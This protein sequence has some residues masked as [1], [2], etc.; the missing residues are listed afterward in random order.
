MI[1]VKGYYYD[2]SASVQT[3][4]DIAFYESGRVLI[5]GGSLKLETSLECLSIASRIG[6]SRRSIYLPDGGKLE[7]DD[8][9]AIDRVCRFFNKNGPQ[10]WLHKLEKNWAYVLSALL[11]TG[12]FVW[13][14]IEFGV[15]IVAK[16]VAKNLPATIER[17]IGEQALTQL[18]GWVFTETEID[19]GTQAELSQRLQQMM[20][21]YETHY[22]YR[23][24]FRSSRQMGANAL[25]LPGGTI[26]MTDAML[27]LAENDEQ[28]LAVL[29]HEIGH[30]EHRHGLRSV[31]Q[32]SLT[33]LFMAGLLGDITSVSSLSVALP[34]LLVESR[35]SRQFELD[36]DRF[37]VELLEKQNIQVEHFIRILTLL[38]QSHG[39]NAEFDYISSHPAMDKRI[40]AINK[41][42]M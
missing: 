16:T 20:D 7:T 32:D 26:V 11:L 10:S 22:R 40:A 23:L 17:K 1:I 12:I 19:A 42:G 30:V 24:L 38:E 34:T 35:Y 8:N 39:S 29:A 31:L 3:P 21:N 14:S 41:R 6:D 4:V 15:P 9:A 28:L 37:A 25:A 18:D 36:A 27:T 13:A 2:G 33:A 5:Q